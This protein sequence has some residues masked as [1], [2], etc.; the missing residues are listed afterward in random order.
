MSASRWQT[1]P[2][3]IWMTGRAGFAQAAGV[4]VGGQIADDD[5]GLRRGP[6]RRMV[7]PISVVFPEPGEERT[8]MTSRPRAWKKPRLRSARRSF[9]SRM[10]CRSSRV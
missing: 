7:S 9:F 3:V 10:A 5:G 2:V 4:V 8:L 6:R 1:V